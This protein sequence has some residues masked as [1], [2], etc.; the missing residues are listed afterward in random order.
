MLQDEEHTEHEISQ[1]LARGIRL[2]GYSELFG[3]NLKVKLFGL[4]LAYLLMNDLNISL[5]CFS[6][7]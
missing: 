5:F 4:E 6:L 1:Q 7:A 2:G 3:C